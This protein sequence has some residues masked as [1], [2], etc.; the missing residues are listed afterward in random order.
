MSTR[1]ENNGTYSPPDSTVTILCS[2]NYS[3]DEQSMDCEYGALKYHG[4]L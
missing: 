2:S 4:K 3:C 1:R